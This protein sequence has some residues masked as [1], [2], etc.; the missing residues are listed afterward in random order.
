MMRPS[1]ITLGSVALLVAVNAGTFQATQSTDEKSVL[2]VVAQALCSMN[3]SSHILLDSRGAYASA[4]LEAKFKQIGLSQ[5]FAKL[6][7][8]ENRGGLIP[9][10]EPYGCL[11][12]TDGSKIEDAF[13]PKGEASKEGQRWAAF[14][15]VFP[16]VDGYAAFSMPA[17][18]I[19]GDSAVVY[20]FYSCGLSCGKGRVYILKRMDRIWT[21]SKELP[22]WDF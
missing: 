16:G 17:F 3:K 9:R 11:Q 18:S 10:G 15:K 2:I 8:D 19:S 7:L 22:L 14:H 20:S 13:G 1:M 21:V 4:T 5:E 12:V 6:L